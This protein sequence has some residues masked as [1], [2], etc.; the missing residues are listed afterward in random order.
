MLIKPYHSLMVVVSEEYN[1]RYEPI[2]ISQ[3]TQLVLNY[4]VISG[5]GGAR[6]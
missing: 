6:K 2:E 4:A 1:S 5:N 3:V